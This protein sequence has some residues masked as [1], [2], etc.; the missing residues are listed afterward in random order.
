MGYTQTAERVVLLVEDSPDDVLLI[1]RTLQ[2][3]G[4]RHRIQEVTSGM[5]AI[6]YLHGDPPYN[7]RQKHPLPQLM[8][9]DIKMPGT[10][11]FDV[12]R[13]MHHEQL[14]VPV[15]MLTSSDE[16]RDVNQAY[17]LGAKSFLVKPLDFVNAV[18]LGRFL[19]RMLKPVA[20]LPH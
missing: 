14:G 10:D 13:W 19:D 2:R 4:V 8:L 7:D 11:G 18:E 16:I 12:L 3:A 1:K 6:A 5:D 15:V 20:D 9:L 17:K